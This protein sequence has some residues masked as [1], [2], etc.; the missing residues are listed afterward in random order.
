MIPKEI[1]VVIIG[2]VITFGALMWYC[3][4]LRKMV[5]KDA[6]KELRKISNKTSEK[7]I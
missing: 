1:L 4:N 3:A 2:N 7:T 5:E 6:Q